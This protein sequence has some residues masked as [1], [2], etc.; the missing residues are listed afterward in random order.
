MGMGFG[1]QQG[2]NRWLPY[3]G[4]H[5]VVARVN[6]LGS[7]SLWGW[8]GGA[9]GLPWGR[10]GAGKSHNCLEPALLW[11]NRNWDGRSCARMS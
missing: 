3:R 6:K 5:R 8:W 11:C 10:R 7:C 2:L 4:T 1:W 9:R